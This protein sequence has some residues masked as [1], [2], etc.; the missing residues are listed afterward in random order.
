MKNQFTEKMLLNQVLL[1][2]TNKNEFLNF[3]LPISE[4]IPLQ[5]NRYLVY[6]RHEAEDTFFLSYCYVVDKNLNVTDRLEKI[7]TYLQA[8]PDGFESFKYYLRGGE[9][10][11][12]LTPPSVSKKT[13]QEKTFQVK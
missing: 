13:P 11:L 8:H 3:D 10:T 4:V 9:V 7:N 6:Q 2:D 5:N 1:I 12:S